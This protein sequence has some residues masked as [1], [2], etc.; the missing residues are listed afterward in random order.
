M[1][2]GAAVTCSERQHVKEPVQYLGTG[3][4]ER[5]FG[6][7]VSISRNIP[8]DNLE[9]LFSLDQNGIIVDCFVGDSVIM[10][11]V[12]GKILGQHLVDVLPAT[13]FVSALSIIT[14]TMQTGHDAMLECSL[15]KD[16]SVHWHS[17]SCTQVGDS[18]LLITICETTE[19]RRMLN[20]ADQQ[21][22]FMKALREIAV[23]L[24]R[25][26]DSQTL[27]EHVTS[28][29]VEQVGALAAWL[30]YIRPDRGIQEVSFS[31]AASE[32]PAMMARARPT[33]DELGYLLKTKTHLIIEKSPSRLAAEPTRAFFPLVLHEQV[34]GVLGLM[35]ETPNFFTPEC[36][37]FFQTY[38][39]LAASVIQ[40]A[41]LHE[42][43]RRQLSQLQTLQVI[44][45]A[46]LSNLDLKSTV[47]VILE[48]V[49][50][51]IHVDALALLVLDPKTQMLDFVDGFGFRFD[52]FRHSHL[53]L[54]EGFAGQVALEKRVVH[55]KNL[56]EDPQSFSRATHFKGEGFMMYLGTPLMARSEVK[57][58]LEIFQRGP[59]EPDNDWLSLLEILANQIAI[60]IDNSLLVKF[61]QDSNKELKTAYNVT[62]EG[63]SRALELRDRETEG[64]T[65]RVTDMTVY[66]AR[67]LGVPES[68]IDQVRQG[69]LLHDIGKMGI[70]DAILLKPEQLTPEEWATMRKHPIY[71]YNLLSG[72]EHLRFAIDIPLYHHEKWDGTG[73][74]CG[75]KG[76]KIPFAARLFAFADVFDALTSDRP[77]R[78]A[79]PK[80]KALSYMQSQA[81]IQFDP[82]IWPDFEKLVRRDTFARNTPHLPM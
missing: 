12:P 58:V 5:W 69:A 82:A 72:V 10:D 30:G 75:L 1:E 79:W 70:P 18:K 56:K 68:E 39:L 71:A 48:E 2:Q 7:S 20:I 44:D 34:I 33:A 17:V 67:R 15:E 47:A 32:R 26:V 41:R 11:V 31:Q 37:N 28:S 60:A 61:L 14:T 50:K 35:T 27:G 63:L 3:P 52:T 76:E 29:C 13:V 43:S 25:N 42:G 38:N 49:A 66:M 80:E 9:F 21:Y 54:G 55:V 40:N 77:Y 6:N 22:R 36:L 8:K 65:R 53:K 45:Q 81:G 73:Y 78:P 62:I 23:Q 24:S 19:Q 4:L 46:I 51:H 74:P 57:G 16:E 64:H 59:F